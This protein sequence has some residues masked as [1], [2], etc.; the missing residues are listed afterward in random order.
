M[1]HMYNS[2]LQ[3]KYTDTINAILTVQNS[4]II[5]LFGKLLMNAMRHL[6]QQF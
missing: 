5:C 3:Y 2:Y 4:N 6:V 1:I